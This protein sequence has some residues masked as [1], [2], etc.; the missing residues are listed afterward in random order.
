MKF[1][2]LLGFIVSYP[3]LIPADMLCSAQSWSPYPL[4]SA[5]M[6][7]PLR[8][9]DNDKQ[10]GTRQA[11]SRAA[12]RHPL[13]HQRRMGVVRMGKHCSDHALRPPGIITVR[14]R[15]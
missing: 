6:D 3:G 5:R 7:D 11:I 1:S 15:L 13:F 2:Q 8:R 4:A 10:S 12:V 9:P 14:K